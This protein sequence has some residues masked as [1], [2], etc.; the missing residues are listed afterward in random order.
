MLSSRGKLPK[1][2]PIGAKCCIHVGIDLG[3]DVTKKNAYDT[4]RGEFWGVKVWE[5]DVPARHM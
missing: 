1:A 5:M 3:M 2:G 4:P